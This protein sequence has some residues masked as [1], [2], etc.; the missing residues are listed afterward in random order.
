MKK[1]TISNS[2]QVDKLQASAYNFKAERKQQAR[3]YCF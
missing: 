3:R 2:N 1:Y